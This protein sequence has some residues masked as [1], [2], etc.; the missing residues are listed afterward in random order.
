VDF[1]EHERRLLRLEHF[2]P[3]CALG[4]QSGVGHWIGDESIGLVVGDQKHLCPVRQLPALDQAL[5]SSRIAV[6]AASIKSVQCIL[7]RSR[8]AR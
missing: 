7:L 6:R 2:E 1:L 3:R 8:A 4:D 5:P